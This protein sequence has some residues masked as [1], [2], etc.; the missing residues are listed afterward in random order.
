MK[1]NLIKIVITLTCISLLL[2]PLVTCQKAEPAPVAEEE[3]I[4]EIPA[5]TETED[6]A[7]VEIPEITQGLITFFSGEVYIMDEEEWWEVGIGDLIEVDDILKTEADSYCE[8]QFGDT[9]VVRVQE[10][11]Q[12]AMSTISLSE[13]EANVKLN[14][15]VGGVLC[16]VEKLVGTEDFK[17]ETQTTVCGVRGTEFAVKA[18]EDNKTVLA[19]KEGA[20]A[21]LPS[22]VD[23]D[24]LKEKA[25]DKEGVAEIIEELENSAPLVSANEEINIDETT[26]QA[27]AETASAVEE[28]V[29]EI[30][31]EGKTQVASEKMER[32]TRAVEESK[33]EVAKTVDPPKKMSQENTEELKTIDKMKLLDIPVA[34]KGEKAE[35]KE[36][37]KITLYKVSLN[38]RPANAEI[39]LNG[40]LVGKGKFS[41]I[42][43]EGELLKFDVTRNGYFDHSFSITANE[44]TAKLYKIELAKIPSKEEVT[45]KV[46]PDDA[47]IVLNGDPMGIGSYK[48]SFKAG[49]NL[50]F[51]MSKEGY[52]EQKLDITVKE[53]F[54]HSYEVALKQLLENIE[55]TTEPTDAEIIYEGE[56]VGSGKYTGSFAPGEKVSFLIRK[57][58]YEEQTVDVMVKKGQNKPVAVS[59]KRLMKGVQITTVPAD[60]AIVLDGKEVGKGSYS[61]SF[62]QGEKLS[63][64]IQKEGFDS[65]TLDVTVAAQVKSYEVSL[66][67]QTAGFK[68]VTEPA[69]AV[70]RLKGR[71]VGRGTYSASHSKGETLTFTV[72]RQGYETAEK[73]FTV[74]GDG[75]QVSV[76][77]VA[78]P[79]ETRFKV[80]EEKIVGDIVVSGGT[81][82]AVDKSGFLAAAHPDGKISWTMTTKNSPN[83]NSYPVISGKNICFSGA[84]ELLIA[85]H[86][87]GK[88]LTRLPLEGESAHLFGRRVVPFN[89]QLLLP[90]NESI[91]IIDGKTG[92]TAREIPISKGSRM[93]PG[94]WKGKIVI[95]DQQGTLMIIDGAGTGA[96]QAEISTGAVQPVALAVTIH[97]DLALFSGRKGTIVC[98]DLAAEKVVWE[99]KIASTVFNDISAGSS[100][101][102]VYSKGKI[103]G[104]SITD[105]S[106]LFSPIS[107]ATSPPFLEGSKL[108]FG[109]D[110]TFVT[111]GASNG[112]IQKTIDI[113]TTVTAR[114]AKVNR[115]IVAGTA[116]G[117]LI[118][119][120][121]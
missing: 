69:D 101:A 86:N 42:Y 18:T 97:K 98:V 87:S 17:V 29:E 115:T 23:V 13:N 50:S 118:V 59:L 104:L 44:T 95:V 55:I 68:L 31:K 66:K 54:D 108:Y 19:V 9:A 4:E 53:G 11:T 49:E 10:N 92:A 73:T 84:R 74:S 26:L 57:E 25:G 30:A 110:E 121:P 93:T 109:K 47:A 82:F 3:V 56:A 60:A 77:L 88:I 85:E 24:E 51:T 28:I 64:V 63:F 114:P 32:L 76:A 36:A 41:G 16:K 120:N 39:R 112:K 107:G 117:E 70:I 83:E 119:F 91:K 99:N 22:N 90:G 5:V 78:K 106:E 33:T 89:N 72:S 103:Y 96:I 113:A 67:A 15:K 27:T 102:Y 48:G 58:G 38:I 52:E 111:A 71:E 79:I 45:L 37:P 1:A 62:E 116:S 8:I 80:T 43:T 75:K 7:P 100:G 6:L 34:T 94:L 46:T 40:D 2:L 105:G 65:K 12:L 61:G 20:V 14:L 81:V 35:E 21:V